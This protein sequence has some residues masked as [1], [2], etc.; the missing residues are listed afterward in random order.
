MPKGTLEVI[1]AEGRQLKDKDT[2]GNNDAYVEVF[3]DKD[4]KQR[5]TTVSNT[6]DPVW[7]QRFTFN[8]REGDDTIRFYIYDD[9]IG[10]K[11]SIG[12]CKVKLRNV[13]DDG[14]FDEWVKLPVL[15]GLSSHGELHIIMNFTV[16]FIRHDYSLNFNQFFLFIAANMSKNNNQTEDMEPNISHSISFLT[17]FI[18][19]K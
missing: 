1:I 15:L 13:F 5:T 17:A 18:F 11:D 3:I 2:I 6:N 12:R 10:D 9:D 14:K 19:S 7:N 16:G 4:Y 8:I